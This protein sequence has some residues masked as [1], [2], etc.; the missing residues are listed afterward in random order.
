MRLQ[1]VEKLPAVNQRRLNE[2]LEKNA[3]GTIT[4][5]E[6]ARLEQLVAEAEQLMVANA[7]RLAEFAQNEAPSQPRR[8]RT[9]TNTTSRAVS[10]HP[11][12]GDG[13]CPLKPKW[14]PWLCHQASPVGT[15]RTPNA[16]SC[17]RVAP[18][19]SRFH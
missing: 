8:S 13:A 5:R 15:V 18:C 1:K 14:R 12:R 19:G 16:Q 3:E 11:T 9:T 7:R 10:V 17:Q 2:L 4:A 6:K